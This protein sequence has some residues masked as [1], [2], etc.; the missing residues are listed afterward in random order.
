MLL[1][2]CVGQTIL[3]NTIDQRL[4]SELGTRPQVREIVR[5]VGHALSAGGHDNVGIASYDG[6]SA[7]NEGLDRGGAHL[8][9]GGRNSGFG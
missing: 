3:Q 8:V 7:N 1:L 5:G 2:V 4:V 9:D 6:L